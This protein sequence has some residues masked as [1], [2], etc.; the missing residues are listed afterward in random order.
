M[1][2]PTPST[3]P[4]LARAAA[5]ILCVFLSASC[6]LAQAAP[7]Q[8]APP[9]GLRENTPQIHT[10]VG[11]RIVLAPGKVIPQGTIVLRDGVI[12]AVGPDVPSR[13]DAR[14]WD[15]TGKTIYPGLIDAFTQLPADAAAARGPAYWNKNVVAQVR[16]ADLFTPSAELNKKLRSQGVTVR[17]VAPRGGVIKGTSAVVTTGDG[18]APRT[19]LTGDVAMHV[20]LVPDGQRGEYPSSPM[21]AVALVRQALLDA[22]WYGRAWA[23]YERGDTTP[24]PE[25]NEALAALDQARR[26]SLPFVIE[27]PDWLYTLRADR[28]SREFDLRCIVLGS[29]D[30][31]RRLA[32]VKATDRTIIV[33]VNF[34]KPPSVASPEEAMSVSLERLMHWDIAPE[35]PARLVE[36]G[37]TIALTTHGLK[38]PATF[39]DGVRKAVARGLSPEAALAALTV[40][41]AHLL[42]VSDRLGT[43][44]TGKL[45]HLVVT[46]GDL[47]A[48][49]TKVLETW[50]DGLRYEVHP[51]PAV[52]LRGTWQLVLARA[53]GG[54]E[55][56]RLILEGQPAALKGK[57]HRGDNQAAL[58]KVSLDG[59][60]LT[61]ACKG[62]ALGW[63]G[64]VRLSL[65]VLSHRSDDAQPAAAAVRL[66]G[67]LTWADGTTSTLSGGRHDPPP[68]P[69]ETADKSDEPAEPATPPA[70]LFPVNFPL[71]AS[72]TDSPPSAPPV[73]AFVNATV[74]TC[75]PA[76]VIE[77]GTI[78]VERGRITTVGDNV[79]V[80][81]SAEIVDAQ[82]GHITPGIIDCHSHIATDGGVN[83][84]GQSITAEVRIGD[85]IDPDDMNIYRQLAGGVT[86]ANILHGSANTI[87]GQNQVIKFRWAALPEEMKFREAPPGI[88]FALGENVKQSNW[89]DRFRTRYPQTRMGVEQLL[90]DAFRAAT[91]YRRTWEEYRRHKRGLPPRVDLELEALAEVLAGRRLIH[92]HS[93]RQDEILALLRVCEEFHVRIATLQHILEGYK[94]ADVIARHGAG[95][96]SFADWWA[97]KF[98]VYD[99]IPYNGA[100]MHQA[101]VVVSFNSDDAELARR[102]N[103][104]AAK[105]VKYGGVAPEEALK[106]VT[107]NPARQ[108]GIDRFVGS[109]EPGKHADLVVWSGPPLS[110]TSRCLQTWIDGRRYFD[111]QEDL[112]RRKRD[113]QRH[114]ALVQHALASGQSP[115]GPD[116]EPKKTLWPRHDIFCHHGD[117][118]H[119]DLHDHGRHA[120]EEP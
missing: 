108:L 87:G 20:Q 97:Y 13:P 56:L 58:E 71:G 91:E 8:T 116:D 17:L 41:P 16:A 77:N 95:G 28:L 86:C 43:I 66:S 18:D 81:K 63:T 52:D 3:P 73:V 110:T 62:D 74:W 109:L 72:G 98:E 37:I 96:S 65:T 15:M 114:A 79:K 112:A 119:D 40:T 94:L 24:R 38:D 76:G 69:P 53:D 120:H 36:A 90:R 30:E 5:T 106:F 93:Y 107:L 92:C 6:G 68:A 11:A 46:D 50:V 117:D 115:A 35:N 57:L 7:P 89:G 4:L 59:G 111:R 99:A 113:A 70:A 103:L 22:D 67:T 12:L 61:A 64:T 84:S 60:Q 100:I 118:H 27:A 26:K 75:G 78:L 23:A 42:G 14:V 10:L 45:A 85:F 83:E 34:P 51:A 29:G 101:G 80:P 49:K 33:P 25:R 39:L 82:R 9:T 31:Y 54:S 55:S 88:K 48:A 1:M 2:K 44:E 104:E 105:A 47:L 19:L 21:G 102:L 32:A